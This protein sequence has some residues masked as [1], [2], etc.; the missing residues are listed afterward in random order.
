MKKMCMAVSGV[1]LI[2]GCM[3][4]GAS[5][6]LSAVLP[7]AFL[8]YLTANPSNF[9]HDLLVPDM[10]GPYIFAAA[11]IISGLVGMLYFGMSYNR[12]KE[13]G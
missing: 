4:L 2:L 9:S 11:E 6:M 7:N 12:S 10:T 3:T 5:L 8:V 13:K 1:V